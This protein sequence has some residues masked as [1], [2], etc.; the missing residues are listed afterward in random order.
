MYW[1]ALAIGDNLLLLLLLSCCW[2][3]TGEI[4]RGLVV[5]K[6]TKDGGLVSAE[7]EDDWISDLERVKR[8]K[9]CDGLKC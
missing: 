4:I 5:E 9:M 2:W 6:C 8:G 1:S 7:D 3:P